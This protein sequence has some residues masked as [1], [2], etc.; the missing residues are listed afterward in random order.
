MPPSGAAQHFSPPAHWSR[1]GSQALPVG[2][3]PGVHWPA[4]QKQPAA[5]SGHNTVHTPD[6]ATP[7]PERHASQQPLRFHAQS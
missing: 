6:G 2:N 7:G 1:A 5:L 3:S 4:W